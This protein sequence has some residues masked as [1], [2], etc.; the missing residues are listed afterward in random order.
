M[1]D[2]KIICVFTADGKLKHIDKNYELK[3]IDMDKL[4]HWICPACKQ[5][6]GY[7]YYN[8]L[9]NSFCS[10]CKIDWN[11]FTS[12]EDYID[13]IL[14]PELSDVEINKA[15][16]WY[17]PNGHNNFRIGFIKDTVTCHKCNEIF[18]VK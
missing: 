3:V 9:T 1:T 11:L 16:H 14:K 13:K 2:K 15:Y 18:N 12:Y 5:A 8:S 7:E 10:H 17:C 6:L 4:H